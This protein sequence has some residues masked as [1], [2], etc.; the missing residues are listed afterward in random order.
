V[1]WFI[2]ASLDRE[3]RLAGL[4][5][6]VRV[7]Q[8]PD[9]TKGATHLGGRRRLL[10]AGDGLGPELLGRQLGA[11]AHRL[12]GRE[13]LGRNGLLLADTRLRVPAE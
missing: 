8:L 6:D 7:A 12:L 10:L 3:R 9:R 2:A 1:G 11:R 5:A 13:L 4:P